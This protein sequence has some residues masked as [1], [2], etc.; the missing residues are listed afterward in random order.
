MLYDFACSFPHGKHTALVGAS[1]SGKSSILAL[2]ERWYEPISGT[3]TLDGHETR[4]LNLKWMRSQIGLVS[5]EPV[6]MN[7]S[8]YENI[9]HGLINSPFEDA[10]VEKKREMV[11]EAAKAANAFDFIE[12][13]PDKWETHLGER[14]SLV[15]GGQKQRIW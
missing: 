6:L 2:I 8:V 13:L 3:I 14:G 10:S 12:K 15:S 7:L 11:Y 1:G 9:A 4:G 5:Q